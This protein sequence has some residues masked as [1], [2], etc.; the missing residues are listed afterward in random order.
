MM[1]V[2]PLVLANEDSFK[3]FNLFFFD[4][5]ED[6]NAEGEEKM[7]QF[8]KHLRR[9]KTLPQYSDTDREIN[10]FKFAN[11]YQGLLQMNEANASCPQ[12]VE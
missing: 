2:M 12:L 5:A 11:T 4:F 6:A 7:V 1:R 10:E 3:S 8:T 9:S